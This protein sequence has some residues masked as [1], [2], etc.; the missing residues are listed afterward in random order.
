M[1]YL[2]EDDVNGITCNVWEYEV[3]EETYKFWAQ[4][5]NIPVASAKVY[6]PDPE[7]SLWTMYFTEFVP[8]PPPLESFDNID[9]VICPE[10]GRFSSVTNVLRTGSRTVDSRPLSFMEMLS[11]F[12]R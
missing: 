2:G 6:S 4:G 5:T 1:K 7:A 3:D 10:A 9:G 12:N 11:F 8:A